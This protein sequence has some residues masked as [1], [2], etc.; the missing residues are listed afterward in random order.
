MNQFLVIIR[1]A[2]ASG[3]TTIAKQLRDY[4]KKIVWLKVD[5]FKDFFSEDSLQEHQKFVDESALVTLQYLL[6]KGFSVVMEKIFFDPFIIPKAIEAAVSRGHIAK[7]FQINCP[8]EV[9]QKRDKTRDGIKEGCRKPLGDETIKEI[10]LQLEK[11]YYPGA[12]R[13]DTGKM[14]I[15]DCVIKIKKEVNQLLAV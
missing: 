7:V 14:S 15:E 8:V 6:D 4:K 2:P 13:I 10:A 3:K 11:T 9:L 12:I 1:G 5:N